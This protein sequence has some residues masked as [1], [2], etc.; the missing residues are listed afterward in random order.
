MSLF[1]QCE[2]LSHDELL[3]QIHQ[4]ILQRYK[5]VIL[6]NDP[7]SITSVSF[8]HKMFNYDQALVLEDMIEE[9]D[10]L[11]YQNKRKSKTS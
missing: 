9:T 8:G 3:E 11:M 7:C 5:M 1:N 4:R 6:A 10:R 2:E